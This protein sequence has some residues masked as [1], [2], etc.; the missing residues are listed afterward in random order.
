L[1]LDP[2]RIRNTSLHEFRRSTF[3]AVLCQSLS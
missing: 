1:N 3:A 2:V